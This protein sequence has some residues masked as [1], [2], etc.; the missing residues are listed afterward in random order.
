MISSFRSYRINSITLSF[1]SHTVRFLQLIN[2][3]SSAK[4][5]Y[6]MSDLT[7]NTHQSPD[8]FFDNFIKD[9]F[10]KRSEVAN[11]VQRDD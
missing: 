10:K 1:K 4:K 5:V 8:Q 11:F 3:L 2:N 6:G 9:N 7:P